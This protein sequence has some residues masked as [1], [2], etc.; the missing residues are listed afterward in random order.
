MA[1]LRNLDAF[2]F[3][4]KQIQIMNAVTHLTQHGWNVGMRTKNLSN[5]I[6]AEWIKVE[7]MRPVNINA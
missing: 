2:L 3:I 1:R 4:L 6:M 7:S 5:L